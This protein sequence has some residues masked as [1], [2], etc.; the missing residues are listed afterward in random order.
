[1]NWLKSVKEM[2][3]TD[4]KKVEIRCIKIKEENIY[5]LYYKCKDGIFE[6]DNKII[7]RE[8][9]EHKDAV[10]SFPIDDEDFVYLVKQYRTP[11]KDR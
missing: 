6:V 7:K 4:D 11:I 2:I 5:S 1:M 8:L 10:I 9:V 3:K